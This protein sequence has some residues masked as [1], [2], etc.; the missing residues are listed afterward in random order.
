MTCDGRYGSVPGPAVSCLLSLLLA[1]GCASHRPTDTEPQRPDVAP[2]TQPASAE[3]LR[4]DAS[5]IE[6]MYTEMLAIDLPSVVRVAVARNFD[7]RQARQAVT[8]SQGE[9]ESAV[10]AAFPVLVP[11]ALF[12]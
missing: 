9:L 6:P 1:G 3:A 2:A 10:G 12:E 4:L 8:A 11:T 7:I 5:Q